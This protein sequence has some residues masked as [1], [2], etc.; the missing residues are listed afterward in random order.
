VASD[1]GFNFKQDTLYLKPK[2]ILEN[3]MSCIQEKTPH[4]KSYLN[5]TFE[6]VQKLWYDN[7]I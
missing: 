5:G 3:S 7:K 4:L 2:N 1:A 6:G